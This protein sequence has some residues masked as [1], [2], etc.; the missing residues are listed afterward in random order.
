MYK[1]E[2]GSH[3]FTCAEAAIRY[4]LYL[5]KLVRKVCQGK[6]DSFYLSIEIYSSFAHKDI[7]HW[8]EQI[9]DPAT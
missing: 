8:S 2:G 5:V 1:F 4:T 9:L 3:V 7:N 6:I